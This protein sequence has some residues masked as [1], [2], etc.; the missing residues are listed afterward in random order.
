MG[1]ACS[2][3]RG[4]AKCVQRLVGK[5]ERKSNAE[6]VGADRRIILKCILGQHGLGGV[7]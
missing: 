5:P 4:D 7:D 1:V 3:H 2:T 6:D